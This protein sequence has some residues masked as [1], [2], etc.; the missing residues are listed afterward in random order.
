M[1]GKDPSDGA[2]AFL[3]A[4]LARDFDAVRATLAPDVEFRFVTPNK[5]KDLVGPD[6]VLNHLKLWFGSGERRAVQSGVE[7]TPPGRS[8]VWYNLEV[9][10]QPVTKDPRWHR[11][12]QQ[13]YVSAGPGPIKSLGLLCTGFMPVA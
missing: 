2:S 6:E 7:A 8:R 9:R 12:E 1:A 13:V 11:I 5:V 4:F 10:P 3:A